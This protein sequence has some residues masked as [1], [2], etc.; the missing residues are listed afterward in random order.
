MN[1]ADAIVLVVILANGLLG[2]IRGFTWQVFRLASLVLGF[3]LSWRFAV[4]FADGPLLSWL[5]WED[6]TARRVLSYAVIFAGAYLVM[7]L[8]GWWM[9][10]LIDRLRLRSSDRSLGFLL[11][12]LKGCVFVVVALQI[13]L[14]FEPVLPADVRAQLWGDPARNIA[15]SRAASLH[16]RWLAERLNEVIPRELGDEVVV[17]GVSNRIELWSKPRWQQVTEMLE[18]DGAELAAQLGD[19]PL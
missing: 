17:V 16:Q 3:W 1:S 4:R 12:C 5:G 6:A 10:G 18:K 9:R 19:L 8:V 2:A 15:P 13:L 11:G 14:I 7:H